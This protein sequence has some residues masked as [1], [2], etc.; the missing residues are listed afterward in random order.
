MSLEEFNM[1]IN[2]KILFAGDV[3]TIIYDYKNG[4]FE[5]RNEESPRKVFLVTEKEIVKVQVDL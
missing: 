5:I 1:T 4:R 3:Y 2:D